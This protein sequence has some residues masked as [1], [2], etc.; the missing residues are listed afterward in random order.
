M[1]VHTAYDHAVAVAAFPYGTLT[2]GATNGTAVNTGLLGNGFRDV[3]FVLTVGTITNG[4]FTITLDESTAANMAGS[5]AVDSGRVQGTLPVFDSDTDNTIYT[6][7]VRP[8]KQYVR[9]ICTVADGAAGGPIAAV[10]IM[11]A[12]STAPPRRA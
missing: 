7:G 12:G 3:L 4:T 11:S 10:A 8:T 1:G 2:T 6:W 5:T 9:A